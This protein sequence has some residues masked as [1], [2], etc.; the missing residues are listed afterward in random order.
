MMTMMKTNSPG[1]NFSKFAGR[2][3]GFCETHGCGIQLPG[4]F[5]G[6]LTKQVCD[7]ILYLIGRYIDGSPSKEVNDPP[8]DGLSPNAELARCTHEAS[9][10]GDGIVK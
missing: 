5:N 1:S 2:L 9:K 8:V 10:I 7:S 6:K 4:L 3:A